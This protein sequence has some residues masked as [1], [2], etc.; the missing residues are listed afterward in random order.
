MIQDGLLWYDDDPE[1]ALAD[2]VKRAVERYQQKYGHAPDVC[3][4]LDVPELRA[5]LGEGGAMLVGDVKV[6]PS[7]S[8]MRY[9]FWLGV[10]PKKN[11]TT[12]VVTMGAETGAGR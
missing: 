12:Q 2:K 11:K 5:Q 8:V 10:E 4:M 1:R 7:K 6:L 9:H 3:Y